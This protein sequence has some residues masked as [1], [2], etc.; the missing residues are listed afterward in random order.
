MK[1]FLT[2][3]IIFLSLQSFTK[4]DD[5]SEFQIEGISIGD[6]ALKFFSKNKLISNKRNWYNDNKFYPVLFDIDSEN[7][8]QLQLHFKLNDNKYKIHA[9]GG[10]KQFNNNPKDCYPLK[11]KIDKS[12]KKLFSNSKINQV[13]MKHPTDK[14]GKSIVTQTS[15]TLK[16]GTVLS[17]CYD[18]SKNYNSEFR[19][20]INTSEIYDWYLVGY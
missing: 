14:S 16:N 12:L 15:F 19:L 13:E 7:Y 3:F 20:I 5:I 4:A 6:S 11:K 17:A 2:V 1:I 10:H 18:M 8:D 9:V